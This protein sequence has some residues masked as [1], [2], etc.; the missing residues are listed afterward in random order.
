MSA[1]ANYIVTCKLLGVFKAGSCALYLGNERDSH[2]C[3]SLVLPTAYK[4]IYC[5][6]ACDPLPTISKMCFSYVKQNA[7]PRPR[8]LEKGGSLLFCIMA[9][10]LVCISQ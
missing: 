9:L 8:F 4:K 2:H 5:H 3:P 7:S 1:L 10:C 6:C